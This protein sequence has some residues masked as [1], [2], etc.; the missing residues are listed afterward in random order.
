MAEKINQKE[1]KK[2]EELLR[3]NELYSSLRQKYEIL[4][5]NYVES[6]NEHL[7]LAEVAKNQ[8]TELQEHKAYL[9]NEIESLKASIPSKRND[10][11]LQNQNF[12]ATIEQKDLIIKELSKKLENL[13]ILDQNRNVLLDKLRSDRY[14]V[15]KCVKQNA[16]LKQMIHERADT[17]EQLNLDHVEIVTSL[18]DQ[19]NQLY[20]ISIKLNNRNLT[21]DCSQETLSKS[22]EQLAT[23][24]LDL[25][26]KNEKLKK[27]NNHLSKTCDDDCE[28]IKA[29]NLKI[30]E[31]RDQMETEISNLK[32][33][34][35]NLSNASNPSEFEQEKADLENQISVLK[36]EIDLIQTP[37]PEI[38]AN[39]ERQLSR[40]NHEKCLIEQKLIETENKNKALAEECNIIT[41]YVELY[42]GQRLAMKTIVENLA[43]YVDA[44]NIKLIKVY[45]DLGALLEYIQTKIVKECP[46]Y[47]SVFDKLYKNFSLSFDQLLYQ[48]T[49]DDS[50][51]IINKHITRQ[52]SLIYPWMERL[53]KDN[54]S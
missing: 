53:Q 38:I 23:Q 5:R 9:E 3:I 54:I 42:V 34:S 8:I 49:F 4:E 36:S 14:T 30:V 46:Q 43:K 25:N 11:Y 50:V 52:S 47:Q 19:A 45:N 22:Y 41:D 48:V 28:L 33:S 20:D 32:N 1:V 26:V 35:Q 16:Q 7:K 29:L 44:I 12:V 10:N 27:V 24:L 51:E 13:E 6:Q 18:L 17:I 37:K 31:L 40:S 15:E 2:Q 21:T 39:I